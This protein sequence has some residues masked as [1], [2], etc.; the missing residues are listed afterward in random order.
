MEYTLKF[1]LVMVTLFVADVFWALYFL[2]IQEK[3][4]L[5]SGIYGSVIYLLG[6]VAVTQYTED[7]SFII[8]AVIGAFLGTYVTVEWKRRKENKINK[9]ESSR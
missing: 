4:P 5:M 9:N 3:N 8:A 6:A 1:L 2:K 7:K